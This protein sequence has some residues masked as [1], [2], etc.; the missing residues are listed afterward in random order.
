M[1]SVHWS[2]PQL[3][4]WSVSLSQLLHSS[5]TGLSF[6]SHTHHACSHFWVFTLTVPS[7]CNTLHLEVLLAYS[8]T[9][10]R[11]LVQMPPSQCNL[12]WPPILKLWPQTPYPLPSLLSVFL[13]N[14]YY[15]LTY[16]MFVYCQYPTT[17]IKAPR[18]QGLC[19]FCSLYLVYSWYLIFIEWVNEDPYSF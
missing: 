6:L 3:P 16:C 12:P 9:S 11:S 1:W 8:L 17:T 13:Q 10:F 5:H 18:G 15:Y 2:P 7:A 4:L 19:I 14:M